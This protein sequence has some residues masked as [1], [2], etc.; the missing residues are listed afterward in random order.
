MTFC[1]CKKMP[2]T[3]RM[4]AIIMFYCPYR[5]IYLW[6]QQ[7]K[8]EKLPSPGLNLHFYYLKFFQ[9]LPTCTWISTFSFA[10]GFI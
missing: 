7:K 8:N 3:G 9:S 5:T 10:S 2:N 4:E 1:S 6:L